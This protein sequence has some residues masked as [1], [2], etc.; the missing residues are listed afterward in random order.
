VQIHLEK[1]M[2]VRDSRHRVALK[3][4]DEDLRMGGR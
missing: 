4:D 2:R 1:T 3:V